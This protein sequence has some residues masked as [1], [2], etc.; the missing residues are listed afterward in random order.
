MLRKII[1][2]IVPHS[3]ILLKRNIAGKKLIAEW[4]KKG[5]PLP[6]PHPL[7]QF[8]IRDYR[9]KYHLS[10][11]IETGTYMGAMV[12]AQRTYFKNIISIEVSEELYKIAKI[13]FK[14]FNNINLFNG[15]SGEIMPAVLKNI[16]EPCLFWLDGHY[17]SGVTGKGE[18][19]TPIFKELNAIFANNK[20]HIILI[21]DARLFVGKDDYPTLNELLKYVLELNAN[22]TLNNED[23]IIRL[24]PTI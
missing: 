9:K 6:P 20:N 1:K 22:Y 3:L 11:L 12:E 19:N 23:D 16:N 7:K 18:L 21:D 14:K 15:D 17:S 8:I 5:S 2:G 13:N 4:K 10:T 24:T